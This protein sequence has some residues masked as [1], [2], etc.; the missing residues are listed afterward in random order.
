MLDIFHKRK[1]SKNLVVFIHGLNGSKE[2]WWNSSYNSFPDL[3]LE[4][5]TIKSKFDLAYFDYFS[6]L[7]PSS[8]KLKEGVSLVRKYLGLQAK[9]IE[10]NLNI[11]TISNL[12]LTQLDTYG[13]KYNNI[14]LLCH[15]MG[16]LVAKH[17]LI[18]HSDKEVVKK[19]KLVVSLA[20]PHNGATL[21][22]I[23]KLVYPLLQIKN[24]SP[25][26][27]DINGVNQGWI[28]NKD[29]NPRIV[30]FQGVYD[31][32]VS[33]TSSVGYDA[34]A[35]EIKYS[36]DTHS[37]ICKP[38]STDSVVCVA[39]RNLLLE[40]VKNQSVESQ[41]IPNKKA[42]LTELESEDFVIKLIIADVTTGIIENSKRRFYEAELARKI[43]YQL[44]LKDEIAILYNSIEQIYFNAF[45][46]VAAGKIADGDALVSYVHNRITDEHDKLLKSISKINF[47]HK[48]GMMHQIANLDEE[49]WWA[50]NNSVE[51]VED[52]KRLRGGGSK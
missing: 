38:E 21:A 34:N 30:Y 48:I 20:V 14:Y 49:I 25:L 51:D 41:L 33:E 11:K 23:G 19:V 3:L 17:L 39:V 52:Y 22:A 35:A 4:D 37:S 2:T 10:A 6:S 1:S 15:S 18:N 8:V 9:R 40:A 43:F 47:T 46:D 45:A 13:G 44:G 12:L 24:L 36:N 32:V 5:K 31:K 16:G 42:D 26:D 27:A 29:K 28:D 50:R 7:L